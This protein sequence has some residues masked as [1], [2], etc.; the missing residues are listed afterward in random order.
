M[1][2]M[3][4]RNIVIGVCFLLL[5][6]LAFAIWIWVN[7]PQI[8]YGG[9]IILA[10]LFVLRTY[11]WYRNRKVKIEAIRKAMKLE[12]EKIKHHEQLE[13]QQRA[14]GLLKFVDR[15]GNEKWGTPKQ[16]QTW[17]RDVQEQERLSKGVD[18][19]QS[20]KFAGEIVKVR[21]SY[22]GKLYDASLQECPNC[23]A[24]E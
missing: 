14:R 22:C 13:E 5:I 10:V 11:A 19:K 17:Q 24:T 2:L 21:C 3:T 12:E 23:G 7:Y 16:V 20:E 15:D 8:V 4:N 1:R 18:V 6:L 9:A